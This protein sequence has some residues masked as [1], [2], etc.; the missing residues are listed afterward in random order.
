MA[1]TEKNATAGGL[2]F[3][4]KL[5][6]LSVVLLFGYLY[7]GAEERHRGSDATMTADVAG[8]GDPVLT[9][10]AEPKVSVAAPLNAQSTTAEVVGDGRPV[11]DAPSLQVPAAESTLTQVSE[12]GPAIEP[13]SAPVAFAPMPEHQVSEAEAQAFAHAVIRD[14]PQLEQAPN[15]ASSES[16]AAG[17]AAPA[18][19]ASPAPLPPTSPE[20]STSPTVPTSPAARNS[21]GVWAEYEAMRRQAMDEA[22]RRWEQAYRM[23]PAPPTHYGYPNYYQRP[24]APP[25]PQGN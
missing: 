13:A 2:G 6:L 12:P 8:A 23:R 4:P 5:L 20:A 24:V 9:R 25:A 16:V 14:E 15:A 10:P 1:D 18:A 19:Q 22:R 17:I 21:A 7:L 3:L 11:A